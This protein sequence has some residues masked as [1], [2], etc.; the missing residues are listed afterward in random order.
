MTLC[1]GHHVLV[2]DYVDAIRNPRLLLGPLALFADVFSFSHPHGI[3]AHNAYSKAYDQF[4]T[5]TKRGAEYAFCFLTGM[6]T[7]MSDRPVDAPMRLLLANGAALAAYAA[8]QYETSLV[9]GKTCME[10]ARKLCN[11]TQHGMLMLERA[12]VNLLRSRYAIASTAEDFERLLFSLSKRWLRFG[13]IV[14]STHRESLRLGRMLCVLFARLLRLLD[15]NT[16]RY[17]RDWVTIARTSLRHHEDADADA[18]TISLQTLAA[19]AQLAEALFATDLIADTDVGLF[20]EVAQESAR[21]FGSTSLVFS[22]CLQQYRSATVRRQTGWL[23]W[24]NFVEYHGA[25]ELLAHDKNTIAAC[26]VALDHLA[27][28]LSFV[29]LG[30]WV[31]HQH[32]ALALVTRQSCRSMLSRLAW[33]LGEIRH[34]RHYVINNEA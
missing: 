24:L 13:T 15:L 25:A 9:Y 31:E 11:T 20:L 29:T 33:Q 26:M 1:P 16:T 14:D 6:L 8:Q 4:Q 10:Y 32:A 17:A 34:R 27:P 12:R 2:L 3:E 28:A 30:R 22:H 23:E 5:K 18:N 21:Q 19:R 7:C